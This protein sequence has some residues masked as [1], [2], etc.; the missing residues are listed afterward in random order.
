MKSMDMKVQATCG[1]GSGAS[2]LGG[3]QCSAFICSQTD[4]TLTHKCLH[5]LF[6]AWPMEN[7]FNSL[8]CCCNARMASY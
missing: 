6:Q 5:K 1:I 7:S 4:D 2:C 3:W 8:V